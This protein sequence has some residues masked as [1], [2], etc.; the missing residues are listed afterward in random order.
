MDA[1]MLMPKIFTSASGGYVFT[2]DVC[3]SIY[4]KSSERIC[5][6]LSG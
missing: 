1:M 2:G 5:A 3:H 4:A 6:K